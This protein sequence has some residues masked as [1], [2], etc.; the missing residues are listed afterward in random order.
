MDFG[1]LHDTEHALLAVSGNTTVEEDRV[2]I[3]N[4]L[5]D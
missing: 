4:H 5:S 1:H 2:G 3:V